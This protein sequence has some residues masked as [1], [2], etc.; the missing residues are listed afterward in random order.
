MWV[1]AAAGGAAETRSE[2]GGYGRH[3][4]LHAGR[5]SRATSAIIP[6]LHPTAK[7]F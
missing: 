2:P 4:Q 1:R 7:P 3:C 5:H 6:Y